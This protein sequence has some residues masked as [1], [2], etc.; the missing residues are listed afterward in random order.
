[1]EFEEQFVTKEIAEKL[2]AIKFN[3]PCFQAFDNENPSIGSFMLY[4]TWRR[5]SNN[6]TRYTLRPTWK[7][8]IDWLTKEYKIFVKVMPLDFE[9]KVKWYYECQSIKLVKTVHSEHKVFKFKV[10]KYNINSSNYLATKRG[11]LE[12]LN[13]ILKE[14][15]AKS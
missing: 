4:D 9:G 11:V 15:K 8:A 7:Q 13:T 3:Q 2:K 5:F 1:M 6:S 12:A 14:D 10:P